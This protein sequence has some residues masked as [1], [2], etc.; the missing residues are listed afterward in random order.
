[1]NKETLNKIGWFA[2]AMGIALFFS[3]LD[4]VRL[5]LSGHPGSVILPIITTINCVAWASYGWLRTAKDWPI[6]ICNLLGI[7]V[8]ILTAVTAVMG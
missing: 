4:Q 3:Y 1:M 7:V 5:N 6:V 2:S 8:G